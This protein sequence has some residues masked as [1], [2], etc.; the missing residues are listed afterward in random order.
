MK[1]VVCKYCQEINKHHSFKCFYKPKK[2]SISKPKKPIAK[3]S[4]KKLVDLKQYRKL[5]DE[6]FKLNPICEFKGCY[7]TE[8]T[9]HH[10]KGRIGRNLTDISYFKSLCL[11]HHRFVEDNPLEAIKMGLSIK[12]I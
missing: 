9:L 6:Y 8:I 5:R 11:A 12:R 7:S 2:Q 1:D 4:N 10:A 3:F